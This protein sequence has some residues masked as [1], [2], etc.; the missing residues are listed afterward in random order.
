M[1][2]LTNT[3]KLELIKEIKSD[4]G[5]NVKYYKLSAIKDDKK[6]PDCNAKVL[7]VA[8][9]PNIFD[10]TK[11][12]VTEERFYSFIGNEYT[13]ELERNRYRHKYLS[14]IINK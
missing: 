14:A 9:M 1:G 4:F 12:D 11:L 6:C 13:T 8:T 7:K 10:N 2:I 5:R 3:S